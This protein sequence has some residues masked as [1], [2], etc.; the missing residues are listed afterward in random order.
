[1]HTCRLC[2]PSYFA[3]IIILKNVDKLLVKN[4][5]R[6]SLN[7]WYNVCWVTI[8]KICPKNFDPLKTWPPW[9]RQFS[10]QAPFVTYYQS[11]VVLQK[12]WSMFLEYPPPSKKAWIKD[13][14]IV[15]MF[16]VYMFNNYNYLGLFKHCRFV[17]NTETNV[18]GTQLSDVGPSCSLV[19]P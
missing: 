8:F 14:V 9:E 11:M 4:N 2:G 12:A 15:Q 5:K 19:L 3:Y 18:C 17:L 13:K 1:M 16:L 6:F 10:M 7:I